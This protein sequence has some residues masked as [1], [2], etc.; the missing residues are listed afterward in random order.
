MAANPGAGQTLIFV[1]EVQRTPIMLRF[2]A[3]RP[4]ALLSELQ[5]KVWDLPSEENFRKLLP[6]W[7]IILLAAVT[8]KRDAKS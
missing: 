1:V 2:G 3:P 4:W 5:K 8:E 7:L 6:E